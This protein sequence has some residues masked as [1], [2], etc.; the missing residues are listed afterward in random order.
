[1]EPLI[2]IRN[3]DISFRQGSGLVKC[4]DGVSFSVWPGEILCLVGESG[5]GKSITAL[6]ILGLLGRQG[7]V[8]GGEILY[9]GR[10]LLALSQREL[11]AIRGREISMIFQ[12]IMYSLNPVF[13]ISSQLTE[14]I[15]RHLRC[16]RKQAEARA[17]QLLGRTGLEPAAAVMRRYP[18]QLSGGMRQRAMIA[19]ALAC[20]PRLLIA[21]EP[22]TALDVTIQLQIMQ[23]LRALRDETGMAILLITHD[24]GLVAEMADRVVVMYAGQCVETGDACRLLTAPAH[25]Y[26]R[27]LLQAVPGTDAARDRRL[28][29]I[30]GAVPE[31]YHDM[32]G[33]RF[34]ARCPHSDVCG[35]NA[36]LFEPEPGR[37]VRC[38]EAVA[39]VIAP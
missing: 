21:D 10:N 11:D 4:A 16:D 26:T 28:L 31:H 39:G 37:S 19:M 34:A 22:T 30:P 35:G 15:R 8:T 17:L 18:H 29:S 2:E 27:A 1:M 38:C 5:C 13:T 6:S 7:H 9:G 20:G 3:L 24:L 25:P 32:T 14:V 36:H 23:L 33:C 12:D